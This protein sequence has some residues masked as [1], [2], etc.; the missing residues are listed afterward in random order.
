MR[1]HTR[2][3]SPCGCPP[4]PWTVAGRYRRL[5]RPNTRATMSPM[6]SLAPTPAA[7]RP[8]PEERPEHCSNS[9]PI[10]LKSSHPRSI[11]VPNPL[12]SAP[13]CPEAHIRNGTKWNRMEHFLGVA[14]PGPAQTATQAPMPPCLSTSVIPAKA[15]THPQCG[16]S[17]FGN[18]SDS[19]RSEGGVQ[20][21]F[22]LCLNSY[23]LRA[24]CRRYA[25]HAII[26]VGLF[27]WHREGKW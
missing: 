3:G 25:C 5:T 16:A 15:G 23:S 19:V 24:K 10:L 12:R 26:L 6:Y 20:R 18:C 22:S 11:R 13:E 17:P 14:P 8:T 27:A 7:R 1:R 21:G 4:W 9:V 2:R